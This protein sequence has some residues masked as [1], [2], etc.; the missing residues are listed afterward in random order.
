MDDLFGRGIEPLG[1]GH[2]ALEVFENGR[3]IEAVADA[4]IGVDGIVHVLIRDDGAVVLNLVL[5]VF[6]AEG[7]EDRQVAKVDVYKRQVVMSVT[8]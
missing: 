6:A 7:D 2:E 3:E 8:T 1:V 4:L 5:P